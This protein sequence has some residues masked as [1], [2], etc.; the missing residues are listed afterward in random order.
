MKSGL[1]PSH[2]PNNRGGQK[3]KKVSRSIFLYFIIVGGCLAV[4]LIVRSLLNIIRNHKSS[5]GP[6]VSPL[7]A[8]QTDADASYIL[9]KRSLVKAKKN[10]V[11][12]AYIFAGSV[13]SFL[14]P[15]VHWSIRFHLMDALGGES[16]SFVR[17]STEDN[18]N[19]QTGDG[20][21][22]TPDHDVSE[23]NATLRILNPQT[24]EYFQLSTQEEEMQR[25]FPTMTHR[26]FR[27]MDQRR[28]SMFY[29]RCMAYRLAKE[30][31]AKQ[32]WRFDWVVLVRLD[33]GWLEPVL[34]IQYWS[35]D[36]V[37]LTETGFVPYNDQ[38]MLIPRQFSDYLYNLDTKARLPVYCLGGPDVER[39][40]CNKT[41]LMEKKYDE[42][43]I[44]ATLGLCCKDVFTK[45]REGFSETI[46][47]RHFLSGNIPVSLGRFPV[48]LT[49]KLDIEPCYADC[50]RLYYNFKDFAYEVLQRRVSAW[51][52]MNSVDTRA[53]PISE[54]DASRC[55]YLNNEYSPW[56]PVSALE[57]Q[58]AVVSGSLPPVDF[59]RNLYQQ[60]EHVH[61]SLRV[62]PFQYAMWRIHPA[63]NVD[64]CLTVNMTTKELTWEECQMLLRYKS[65]RR[66][67]PRQGFLMLV[68]PHTP[69]LVRN[70]RLQS[71]LDEVR[72]FSTQPL[73]QVTIIAIPRRV[74]F[75]NDILR[76]MWCWTIDERTGRRM[77]APP[78]P[79]NNGTIVMES[80]TEPERIA[81]Q[82]CSAALQTDT[83]AYEKMATE[84]PTTYRKQK[85]LAERQQFFTVQGEA[86]GAH[87]STTVGRIRPI[88]YPDYCVVR[89]ATEE[90]GLGRV[91]LDHSLRLVR[92]AGTSRSTSVKYLEFEYLQP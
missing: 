90:K 86:M 91:M 68:Q 65:G 20:V 16:Y 77:V 4:M 92:C 15:K 50:P 34:P 53:M 10:P 19:T 85:E 43:F 39:W 47:M 69:T 28:Y 17:L 24:V 8:F 72:S 49:R 74:P 37:W 58:K 54:T 5:S 51:A 55:L 76:S 45:N 78:M 36:R 23:L 81:L 1:L 32:S 21:V 25:N 44:N 18:Q 82:E 64:G 56:Q 87:E 30:F 46:H 88:K 14:C 75:Y 41:V 59:N 63:W 3:P 26:V 60:Y 66:H 57:Y 6:V 80:F 33:A 2:H 89:G 48:Y 70:V 79:R 22:Y 42:E 40:K 11:R 27:T 35:N 84:H 73:P 29:H 83:H 12:I 31:E 13:R 38:F 7:S 52:P 62:N 67:D 71:P 61:P 9:E